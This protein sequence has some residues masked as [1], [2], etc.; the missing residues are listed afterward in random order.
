MRWGWL[1]TIVAVLPLPEMAYAARL[2]AVRVGVHSGYARVVL[3]TD[4]PAAYAVLDASGATPD[5]VTVRIAATSVAREVTSALA[6][7]PA[8]ALVPQDDGSTLARI[9]A[10]GPLRVETQ[11]LAA[12]PRVVL[13]LRRA[14]RE[15]ASPEPEPSASP[16]PIASAE[17][18]PSPDA[19]PEPTPF[20]VAAAPPPAIAT[21]P[22]PEAIETQ[23]PPVS[24]PPPIAT[25]PNAARSELD[26][27]SLVLGFALGLAIALLAA[28][29]RRH[30]STPDA[31]SPAESSAEPRASRSEAESTG[32]T[33][34]AGDTDE[35]PARAGTAPDLPLVS[36]GEAEASGEILELDLL[37]MHQRLDARLA[38]IADQLAGLVERQA[39]LESRS[40][41]QTEE[42]ASQRAAIARLQRSL[43]P[44][45][46]ASALA[47]PLQVP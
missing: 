13:D 27:R 4:A 8:V 16:E 22:K 38:E 39:R 10:R 7:S 26:T 46:P 20:P 35:A 31:A 11:V 25:P 45:A 15:A 37:R 21:A 47:R 5:E 29:S 12:P 6:G 19:E 44:A 24:A 2:T 42:I 17:P 32:E 23:A 43:R 40:A 30:H 41:I 18:E 1:L 9:H 33:R 3:E 36:H 14:A 28:A 34:E